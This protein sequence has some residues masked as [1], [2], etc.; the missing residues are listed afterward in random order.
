MSTSREKMALYQG[1]PM[2]TQQRLSEN[3]RLIF[4]V[5]QA[6]TLHCDFCLEIGGVMSTSAIPKRQTLDPHLETAGDAHH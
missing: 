4:V 6:T 1:H 3:Q 2:I 5:Y